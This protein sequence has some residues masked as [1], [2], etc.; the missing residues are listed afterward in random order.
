MKTLTLWI[1]KQIGG[2]EQAKELAVGTGRGKSKCMQ[3]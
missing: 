3:A 2:Q 1:T